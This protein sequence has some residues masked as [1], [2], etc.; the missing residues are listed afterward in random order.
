MIPRS[1][2]NAELAI[3]GLLVEQPR[4]GYE[5]EQVITERG[6]REWTD[7]GFSSIYYVLGR[8]E[9]AGLVTAKAVP[10]AGRGPSRRVH[11][12]TPAGHGAWH[13]ATLAALST[14]VAVD[15]PFLLGLA[16]LAGI[17]TAEATAALAAYA[18]ALESRHSELAAQRRAQAPLP[19]FADALFDHGIALIKAEHAWVTDFINRVS[20]ESP[21]S[22]P[23]TGGSP[24]PSNAP[25][26][27][28]A[29]EPQ[30]TTLPARTMAVVRTTG[31]PAETG[32]RAFPALYGAAYALKFALKKQ[33]ITFAV[34]PPCAR[35]FNGP[36][37]RAVPRS[38]WTAA[39]ALPL[40]DGTT[41]VTQKDPA[42]PVVI[43]TWEYGSVAQVL[44]LGTYAEEEP[45]IEKLHAFIAEQGLEIAGPHEEIY[46]SRPGA[47]NQK[48][49]V[50]YQVR[51][52]A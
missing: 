43:E 30:I 51:R 6:M 49:I 12:V 3:L 31:D 4:H 39:W 37:W 25:A 38:E 40:P 27:M 41:E 22:P 32:A 47:A 13:A 17:P 36:D 9:Q 21:V 14:P 29:F 10:A 28:K 16:H 26:R 11:T 33:G 8:L 46:L 50:R 15:R 23:N 42:V 52:P 24:M 18:T 48:T 19:W 45:T 44:H 35:W 34:E 7:L 20:T 5:I 2:T 1:I